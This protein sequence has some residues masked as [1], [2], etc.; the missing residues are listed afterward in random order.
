MRMN[1]PMPPLILA[2]SIVLV[3]CS[4]VPHYTGAADEEAEHIIV[5]R[6][7]PLIVF[8]RGEYEVEGEAVADRNDV[9]FE[10]ACIPG[11]A[12]G[13]IVQQRIA[14]G[15]L[16]EPVGTAGIAVRTRCIS[17]TTRGQDHPFIHTELAAGEAELAE[18]EGMAGDRRV[19]DLN[20]WTC[21]GR[22]KLLQV[23]LG[24]HHQLGGG[25]ECGGRQ[26]SDQK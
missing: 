14:A 23:G 19:A 18:A 21:Y 5:L 7:H 9:E 6:A 15:T 4:G 17:D 16:P 8:L 22:R 2:L 3:A 20:T 13:H 10:L 12:A 24:R 11:G 26:Y 25:H 1:T